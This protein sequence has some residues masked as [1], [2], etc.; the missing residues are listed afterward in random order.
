MNLYDTFR[1]LQICRNQCSHKS[2]PWS[3]VRNDKSKV[4]SSNDAIRCP[5]CNFLSNLGACC[6]NSA[7]IIEAIRWKPWTC[8]KSAVEWLVD[9]IEQRR[10]KQYNVS[11]TY[12]HRCK[13]SFH[14]NFLSC[15]SKCHVLTTNLLRELIARCPQ[16]KN[17]DK[18]SYMITH[19]A[20]QTATTCYNLLL[21]TPPEQQGI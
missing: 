10:T 16:G 5:T 19:R 3:I 9:S 13:Q 12:L 1:I 18:G 15:V 11:A 4:L 7:T 21:W 6:S 2:I 17:Q 14:D 20:D 8:R